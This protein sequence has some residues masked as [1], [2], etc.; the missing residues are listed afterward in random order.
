[1]TAAVTSVIG[2]CCSGSTMVGMLS[3]GAVGKCVKLSSCSQA[4]AKGLQD[5]ISRV[6]EIQDVQQDI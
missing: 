5:E 2:V 1:M 4:L 6:M 3:W